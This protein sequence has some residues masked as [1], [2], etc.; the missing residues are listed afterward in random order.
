MAASLITLI[1]LGFGLLGW[2][3]GVIILIF[4]IVYACYVS[5]SYY[6]AKNHKSI[7]TI[8]TINFENCKETVENIDFDE[9]YLLSSS[10]KNLVDKKRPNTNFISVDRNSLTPQNESDF[11]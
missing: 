5:A 10:R 9:N 7:P 6:L 1:F 2:I 4:L 11:K 8:A 3:S